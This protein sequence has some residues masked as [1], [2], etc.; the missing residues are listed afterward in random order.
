MSIRNKIV[1]QIRPYMDEHGYTFSKNHFYKIHNDI[2]YCLD[3]DVP[4]GLVYATFFIIPLYMPT[5]NRYY[6]YGNR[7]SSLR[8]SKLLPLS[9]NALDDEL[10]AWCEHLCKDLEKY[11]F[12]FFNEITTPSK[13]MNVIEKKKYLA[14]PFFSCPPVQIS[15]LQLYSYLYVEDFEKLYLLIKKYPLII[16]E[17]TY[18]SE[19]VR[20]SFLEENDVIVKLVHEDVQTVRAFYTKTTQ[21]TIHN[22]FESVR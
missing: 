4:G 17:S 2:A 6:T 1:S 15:R 11:V 21:D 13:L 10:K 7:V 3:F 20:T 22:C 12:P 5:Q 9:K 14:A 18:L 8:R 19:T 16:Q